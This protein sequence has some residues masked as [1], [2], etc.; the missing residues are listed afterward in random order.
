MAYKLLSN[1]LSSSNLTINLVVGV[2]LVA[3]LLLVYVKNNNFELFATSST[4]PLTTSNITN[5]LNKTTTTSATSATTKPIAASTN[6]ISTIP[7]LNN[8]IIQNNDLVN[9]INTFIINKNQQNLY[10]S[11]LADR[12]GQI[13]NLSTQVLKLINPSS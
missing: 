12:Q 8:D 6:P 4:T 11:T 3:I 9:F 1:L 5:P 13:N 7:L 2:S 10:S